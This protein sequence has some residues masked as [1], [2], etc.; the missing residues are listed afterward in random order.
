M[1]NTMGRVLADAGRTAI[2][3]GKPAT[4]SQVL[5]R[6][7]LQEM[8]REIARLAAAVQQA[9]HA[10]GL[11]AETAAEFSWTQAGHQL[12]GW[13]LSL[14]ESQ[15]YIDAIGNAESYFERRI[16]EVMA[17]AKNRAQA[18]RLVAART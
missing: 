9:E 6:R 2:D 1:A 16:R 14:M 12:R 8:R 3:K 4:A 15:A 7:K 11:G 18:E 5:I 13:V 17:V 10:A